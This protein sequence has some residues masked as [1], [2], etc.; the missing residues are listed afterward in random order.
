MTVIISKDG[1]KAGVDIRG[2]G[3]A[4]RETPLMNPLMNPE[5]LYELVFSGGSAFGLNA[6]AG[7]VKYLEEKNIGYYTKFANIGMSKLHI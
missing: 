7:V 5:N 4:S 1:M 3:P 6:S 2:G